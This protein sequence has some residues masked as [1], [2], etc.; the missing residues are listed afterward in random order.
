MNTAKNIAGFIAIPVLAGFG[1]GYGIQSGISRTIANYASLAMIA[2]MLLSLYWPKM[3]ENRKQVRNKAVGQLAAVA[4]IIGLN[5]GILHG[6]SPALIGLGVLA[7]SIGLLQI[8]IYR[9][10]K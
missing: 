8:K 9:G 2:L 6:F 10:V 3:D 1:I 7:I 4:A 5:P